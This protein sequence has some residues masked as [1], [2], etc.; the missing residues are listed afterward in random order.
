V[1][2]MAVVFVKQR[3]FVAFTQPGEAA[4]R[5]RYHEVSILQVEDFVTTIPTTLQKNRMLGSRAV[6]SG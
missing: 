3:G 1:C 2:P 4:G 6:I 5:P